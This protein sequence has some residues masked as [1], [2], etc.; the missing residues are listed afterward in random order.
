MTST[1]H[2][3]IKVLDKG[4]QIIQE[5]A[6]APIVLPIQDV[7]ST[8]EQGESSCKS[9]ENLSHPSSIIS[10]IPS[11]A[12]ILAPQAPNDTTEVIISSVLAYSKTN[13]PNEDDDTVVELANFDGV[14]QQGNHAKYFLKHKIKA[15]ANWFTSWTSPALQNLLPSSQLRQI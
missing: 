13:T 12:D 8:Y 4:K 14:V 10:P 11:P 1:K 9:L 6:L 15:S 5:P 2:E 3:A 7:K